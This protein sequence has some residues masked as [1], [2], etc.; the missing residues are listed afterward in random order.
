MYCIKSLFRFR[1]AYLIDPS[2]GL[3]FEDIHHQKKKNTKVHHAY[4]INLS[5]FVLIKN[6]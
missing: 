6:S 1:F 2:K 3:L 4:I 5:N